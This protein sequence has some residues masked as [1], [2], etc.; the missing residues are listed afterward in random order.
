MAKARR[1]SRE[2][3]NWLIER[4]R[5][6]RQEAKFLAGIVRNE[7]SQRYPPQRACD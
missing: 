3:R 7:G 4:N 5:R 2:D 1:G 6:R